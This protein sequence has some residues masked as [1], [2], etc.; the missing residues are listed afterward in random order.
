MLGKRLSYLR[1][2]GV[3]DHFCFKGGQM[4]GVW[5]MNAYHFPGNGKYHRIEF[6]RYSRDEDGQW[7]ITGTRSEE[8]E[9]EFLENKPTGSQ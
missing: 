6:P 9:R 3:L 7:T 2:K 8:E 5:N 4:G 1:Q